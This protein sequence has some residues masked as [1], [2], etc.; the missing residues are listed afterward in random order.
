[1]LGNEILSAC[2]I[3][4]SKKKNEGIS[5]FFSLIK[6]KEKNKRKIAIQFESLTKIKK[7]ENINVKNNLQNF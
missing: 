7:E 1:M 6:N 2:Q 4:A 5:I 3:M